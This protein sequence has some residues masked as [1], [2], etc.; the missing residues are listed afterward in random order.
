MS[1]CRIDAETG[2]RK[3]EANSLGDCLTRQ[4]REQY[5]FI[6]KNN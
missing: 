1:F 2:T 6:Y 5:I 3:A 4:G